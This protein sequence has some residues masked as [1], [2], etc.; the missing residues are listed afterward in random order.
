MY[1]NYHRIE[2]PYSRPAFHA[3]IKQVKQALFGHILF[4]LFEDHI[5]SLDTI[6]L[7][8]LRPEVRAKYA[9]ELQLC[10]GKRDQAIRVRNKLIARRQ[11][12]IN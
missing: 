5:R 8:E 7:L 3:T 4:H 2:Q 1:L 12:N 10:S 9:R 6:L 11:C